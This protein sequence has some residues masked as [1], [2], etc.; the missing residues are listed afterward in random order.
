MIPL[1]PPAAIPCTHRQPIKL[2]TPPLIA[3]G[4]NRE[5]F[6]S[7]SKTSFCHHIMR[8]LM[9]TVQYMNQCRKSLASVK[10]GSKSFNSVRPIEPAPWPPVKTSDCSYD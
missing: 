1:S 7:S 2:I 10:D 4:K 9:K 3:M 6:S 8:D 5:L